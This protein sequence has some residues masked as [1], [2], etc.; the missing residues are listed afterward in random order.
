MFKLKTFAAVAAMGVSATASAQVVLAASSWLPPTHLLSLRLVH[1]N[2]R[3]SR[4]AGRTASSQPPK[5]AG[6]LTSGPSGGPVLEPFR[7]RTEALQAE[8]GRLVP[9]TTCGTLPA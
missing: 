3:P 6:S 2:H 5:N 9:I 8:R 4:A 7:S 1:L